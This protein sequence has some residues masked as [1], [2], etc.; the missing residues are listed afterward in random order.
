MWIRHNHIIVIIIVTLWRT[1]WQIK[2]RNDS[3]G[4]VVGKMYIITI[5]HVAIHG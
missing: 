5:P 4:R 1:L 2:E 3:T